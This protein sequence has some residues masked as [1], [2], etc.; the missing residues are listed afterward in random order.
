MIIFSFECHAMDFQSEQNTSIHW[1]EEG[2][3]LMTS[4]TTSQ[5]FS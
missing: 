3:V 1:K 4:I 5:A 2:Q